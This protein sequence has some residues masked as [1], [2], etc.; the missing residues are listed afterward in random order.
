MFRTKD[1]DTFKDELKAAGYRVYPQTNERYDLLYQRLIRD[2]SNLLYGIQVRFWD[3]SKYE[4][5]E[6][7]VSYDAYVCYYCADG[8][9]RVEFSIEESMTVKQLE[10]RFAGFYKNNNCV[11]DE[12]NN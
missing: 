4:R 2:G 5:S 7:R 9:F 10:A 11:P 12:L 8:M 3:F 6:G 1:N